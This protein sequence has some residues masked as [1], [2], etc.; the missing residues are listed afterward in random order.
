[1]D[2]HYFIPSSINERFKQPRVRRNGA[3][4]SLMSATITY[5]NLV[6]VMTERTGTGGMPVAKSLPNLKAALNG[7][8]AERDLR[9]DDA[10]GSTF[11]LG[12][13]KARDA[14]LASLRAQ[15]RTASYVANRK[16]LLGHWHRLL[17]VLDQECAARGERVSG[18]QSA[19]RELFASGVS[20]KGT[21]RETNVP[22]ATLKNWVRG[23]QPRI[24]ALPYLFRLEQYF[25]MQ[26]GTL[27][28]FVAPHHD[29]V[30][31]NCN[32]IKIAYREA[33]KGQSAVRYRL[34]PTKALDS[35]ITEWKHLVSYKARTFLSTEA[36][37]DN[38]A[39]RG[40]HWRL[41]PHS[42]Q[43]VDR[44]TWVSVIRGQRCPTAGLNFGRVAQ[45]IGWLMLGRESG[46]M[47]ISPNKAQT[48]A[49]LCNRKQLSAF[50]AW[51]I[52]RAGG[53][54][55]GGPIGFLMFVRMLCHPKYGFLVRSPD[56]GKRAGILSPKKWSLCCAEVHAFCKTAIGNLKDVE[57]PSR[58]S[59]EPI[60]ALLSLESPLDAIAD[61]VRRL[62]AKSSGQSGRRAAIFAR[63]RL[64]LT[65]TASN[66]LRARNLRELTWRTD[67]T[68][69]LRQDCNGVWRIA[70]PREAFKNFNGAAR[71]RDY[72]MPIQEE[73]WP[74][75]ERY[76]RSYRP[77]LVK[78][79]SDLVFGSSKR[80]FGEWQSLNKRF[81]YLMGKYVHGCPGVGPHAMRHIVATSILKST[82]NI[83]AAA[84]VL[85][86]HEE[87]VRKHYAH[88]ISDDG[89][90]W[91]RE[92]CGKSF[93]RMQ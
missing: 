26:S 57:A 7:F 16:S 13:Y 52:A 70:L 90:R 66:P 8:L 17:L 24:G 10:I 11:R 74:Y 82:G 33:L 55:N 93:R 72:D 73:L 65:L 79:G 88:L 78:S 58:D 75:I 44:H 36:L 39:G 46:G 45:Y 41:L 21:S 62:D 68:G 34:T 91:L 50:L 63:D 28:D 42:D 43:P 86:D 71:E 9:I 37:I 25:G 49:Q 4:R 60:K 76:L 89:A 56:L 2:F 38:K 67:N 14:H 83:K 61:A 30:H 69:H 77:L 47:G 85:H 18:L 53:R 12:F 22:L 19:L 35:F 81:A 59:F 23:T 80:R 92:A 29:R 31:D 5:E 27:A 48:L 32:A 6:A 20:M 3:R 15:C 1:M 51:Q 40:R 64:L 87:T 84:L 54:V